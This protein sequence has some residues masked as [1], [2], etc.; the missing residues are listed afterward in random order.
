VIPRAWSPTAAVAACRAPAHPRPARQRCGVLHACVW[1][2]APAFHQPKK[3]C[4]QQQVATSV[5]RDGCAVWPIPAG[6]YTHRVGGRRRVC[7][8]KGH[9]GQD[10]CRKAQAS[11]GQHT[12]V[13]CFLVFGARRLCES[14]CLVC[15]P[16]GVC[17][18]AV[19][20]ALSWLVT[21]QTNTVPRCQQQQQRSEQCYK[22]YIFFFHA[23]GDASSPA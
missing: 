11:V 6:L 13:L 8:C 21:T 16:R 2:V 9:W 22:Q 12:P 14:I 19:H 1:R 10:L 5:V 15:V 3:S 23:Q 17:M 20:P 7:Q 4:P 18:C